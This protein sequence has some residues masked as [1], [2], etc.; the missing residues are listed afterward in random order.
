MFS[1]H[2]HNIYHRHE[3]V[4]PIL[5]QAL[6]FLSLNNHHTLLDHICDSGGVLQAALSYL[7]LSFELLYG[8]LVMLLTFRL[9]L[10]LKTSSE[11]ETE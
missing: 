3:R 9:P 5:G 4:D 7:L 11:R 2:L 8:L 10:L 6:V 1:S